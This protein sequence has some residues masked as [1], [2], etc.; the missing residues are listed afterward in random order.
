M[1][2]LS[3]LS[4]SVRLMPVTFM[5]MGLPATVGILVVDSMGLPATAG[6]LVVDK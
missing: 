1:V 3:A 4:M 5:C 2:L 6:I